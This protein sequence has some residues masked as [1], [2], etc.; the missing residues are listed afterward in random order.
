VPEDTDWLAYMLNVR[1][2]SPRTLGLMH[3]FG[4]VVSNLEAAHRRLRERGVKMTEQ[5]KIVWDGKWQLNLYD[6]DLTRIELM[7]P[8]QTPCCSPM[9]ME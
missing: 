5:P 8:V 9:K 2:P 3:H 6:P 7:K 4:L 1:N